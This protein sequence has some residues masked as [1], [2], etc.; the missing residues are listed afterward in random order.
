VLKVSAKL[1]ALI[2]LINISMVTHM[3]MQILD[4]HTLT[5][6]DIAELTTFHNQ[7]YGS[8][9]TPKEWHWQYRSLL[10]EQA[11]FSVAR[12][13]GRI[14]AT[15]AMMP[16][17]LKIGREVVLTGKSE[18]TLLMPEYRGKGVMEELYETAVEDCRAKG[19]SF[20]WGFTNAAKAF[21]RFGFRVE[22][23]PQICYRGGR[24]PAAL[25]R[26]AGKP[27]DGLKLRLRATGLQWAKYAFLTANP[28]RL[29]SGVRQPPFQPRDMEIIRGR[30]NDEA[31]KIFQDQLIGKYPDMISISLDE[32]Y[33]NW[34]V[35]NN[36]TLSYTEYLQTISGQPVGVAF[37]TVV[38]PTAS[39]SLLET[40]DPLYAS[41]LLYEII[42][43][44][45]GVA[46]I[47]LFI[48][49]FCPLAKEITPELNRLGFYFRQV[50]NLVIR[51]LSGGHLFE[52]ENLRKWNINN[53]W[54][55]GYSR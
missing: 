35:R 40:I 22:P 7:Y 34:R 18:N 42:C 39:I 51:D 5:D 54:T 33:V 17:R 44:H 50:D 13:N 32:A 31:L 55:E 21:R 2:F 24:N 9:R 30:I 26:L 49:P 47:Q 8:K 6:D 27:G 52:V 16:I 43:R 48:N 1:P 28:N 29:M 45:G 11:V 46:D 37:V 19:M 4:I 3:Q 38:G 25:W 12:D 53:L 20:L 14:I 15:Q 10:P 36:P 23:V 41:I